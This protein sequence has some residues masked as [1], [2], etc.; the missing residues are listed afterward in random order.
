MAEGHSVGKIYVEL[1][2]DTDRYLKG[3]KQLLKDATSTSLNIEQNFKNLGIKSSAEMDLMRA[4]VQNS[5][6]MIAQ[7]AKS[8]ANDIIRAERA[9]NE[10]LAKLAEQQFGTN[11]SMIKSLQDHW[12]A[13]SVTAIAA[14]KAVQSSMSGVF[15]VAKIGARYETLGVV[16]NVVGK[17]AGYT[18]SEIDKYTRSLQK[19][20]ISMVESRKAISRM[21]QANLDLEKSTLLARVAQDAAVIGNINSS[22]A[23]ERLIYG[24]QS[25]QVKVLRTIGINVDFENSYAKVAKQTGR[26]AESFSETE[27][28]SIRMNAALEAGEQ[29]AG[30]YEAAMQTAGKQLTSFPRYLEDFKVKMGE[31]F[32]PATTAT[33]E[34]ATA[35]MKKLTEQ[36]ERPETQ[37]A[38]KDLSSEISKLIQSMINDLP[39]AVETTTS[40]MKALLSLYNSM[41]DGVV[42]AAGAGLIGRLLFGSGSAGAVTS[43]LYVVNNELSKVDMGIGSLIDKYNKLQTVKKDFQEIG[44]ALTGKRD[45][46]TGKLKIEQMQGGSAGRIS[47]AGGSFD[48]DALAA[49]ER[50]AKRKGDE[51]KA[52]EEAAAKKAL[53]EK[54]NATKKITDA[55]RRA[56]LD[57]ESIG[58]SQYE[59]D[60]LRINAAVAEY[61]RAGVTKT[62]ISKYTAYE[63]AA[64]DARAY[65]EMA[66]NAQKHEKDAISE[67]EAEIARGVKLTQDHLKGYEDYRKL[68]SEE[69]VYASTENERAINAIIA[70]EEEK[71]LKVTDLYGLGYISFEE[72]EMA[73]TLIAENAAAARYDVELRQLADTAAFYSQIAGYEDEYRKHVF[74]WIDKEEERLKAFYDDDVAAAKWA[75]QQKMRVNSD[76]FYKQ[77][78]ENEDAASSMISSFRIMGDLYSKN[79]KER[80]A[81]H[82][83]EMAAT[84]AELG[85]QAQKNL[86]IAVG[87]VAQQGTGDPY[88]AFARIAAMI[89]LMSNVLSIANLNFSVGGSGGSEASAAL[90]K[91]T[92]LGAADGTGSESIKNVWEMLEDTYSM[93]YRE[94]SGIYSEMKDLNDNITGLVTGIVRTGGITSASVSTGYSMGTAENLWREWGDQYMG[95][96][97]QD[98]LR[99]FGIK[100]DPLGDWVTD[101]VGDLVSSIF[102]GGVESWVDSSG[103]A[104]LAASVQSLTSGGGVGGRAYTHVTEKHDGGWFSDDWYS[105][106]TVY[107]VLNQ[108]VSD[109]LDLV[110]RNMSDTLIELTTAL[111][112]DMNKTLNYV[113]KDAEINLQGMDSDTINKTL[114][115]Y[116]SGLGDTAVEDLFGSMLKGYQQLNEGLMETAS[117]LI[118]DKAVIVDTL[119]MTGQAFAGTIPEMIAFSETLIDLAGDLETLRENAEKYYDAFFTDTEKQARLQEQLSATLYSM[120]MALPGT[121]A[122]YRE[123]LESLDLTTESGQRAY[124]TLLGLA[125]AADTYYSGVE[126]LADARYAQ[127]M[128]LLEMTGTEAEILAAKRQKELEAM[129]ASLRPLQNLIYAL[130]DLRAVQSSAASAVDAQISAANS[131]LSA[132]NSA[133]SAYETIVK[134]ITKTIQEIRG[135]TTSSGRNFNAL[136]NEA[137]TGDKDALTNLSQAAKDYLSTSLA[138]A[139]TA[140]EYA[141]IQGRV[142]TML[143][144]ATMV[145]T[146]GKNWNEYQAT[147]LEAQKSI[148]ENIKSE[149]E[150]TSP[151]TDL[152]ETQAGLLSDIVGLLEQQAI[153]TIKWNGTQYQ[154]IQD[155]TGKITVGNTLTSAQTAQVITGNATQDAIKNI[156]TL[157]T[158]YSE[159]MLKALVARE[160]T[161]SSSLDG[162]LTANSETVSALHNLITLTELNLAQLAAMRQTAEAAEAARLAAE[163][164]AKRETAERLAA[165]AKAEAE[166]K[167]AEAAASANSALSV[168]QGLLNTY[169]KTASYYTIAENL[170]TQTPFSAHGYYTYGEQTAQN[171]AA[172]AAYAAAFQKAYDLWKAIP[173]HATGLDYVPYDDYLM[174]AHEGEAVLP[175]YEADDWRLRKSEG[176]GSN[177]VLIEELRAIKTELKE[178]KAGNYQVAKNT[179]KT[180]KALGNA[181]D[182][183]LDANGMPAIRTAAVSA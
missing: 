3:Q 180:A 121:R 169:E 18:A 97:F 161:Q 135:I 166:K 101:K 63:M 87:A 126:D 32:N 130:E 141:R 60:I 157:N 71:L 173:G 106:Y 58:K 146:A 4:K 15:D 6:E 115:E 13:A 162:I 175:K 104:T 172:A 99:T 81:M 131:A 62:L 69:A 159:E 5:Y 20:G 119:D 138:S 45:W 39:K 47:G 133:A 109:M 54:E 38:L 35:A 56:A 80:Q 156:S 91:S 70:K 103:I 160:T 112:A 163:E 136:F 42:G 164:A 149:L 95:T 116:F 84:A 123:L 182:G 50:E 74:D 16:M 10:Q 158:S 30:T 89:A 8:T 177:L 176:T 9:K 150:K 86:M 102:G 11:Q 183:A 68:M 93:E 148:L 49:A 110:F 107:G 29:I 75:A 105:G 72:F 7:S 85:I 139:H 17:N 122:G 125:E 154:L 168:Y 124:V 52:A 79:S 118:I 144:Q 41:P 151:D 26:T 37:Q 170:A 64:A 57:A 48:N 83:L 90:S 53:S 98:P 178:I 43:A 181:T 147:L 167:Y 27:K 153:Q 21:A 44:E 77:N 55:I 132:A 108:N 28:A 174:R 129:D 92:V 12:V 66:K 127:E 111:G 33:V 165:A 65:E 179:L 142:V 143:S 2:L 40:T 31:A 51:A 36:I 73:K 78:R 22:E 1:D 120:Y 145:S 137:M 128:K 94:L 76:L 61:E 67:M 96:V 134:S 152:L 25:A 140:E 14:F 155:Q 171:N 117:R 24:I 100:F 82:T 46:R 59:K 34:T 23:F 88:T 113:F 114:S 19:S